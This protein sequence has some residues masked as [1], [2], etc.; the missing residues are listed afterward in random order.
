MYDVSSILIIISSVCIS[1]GCCGILCHE[2][3]TNNKTY[4]HTP[5]RTIITQPSNIIS[6]EKES[7]LSTDPP[8]YNQSL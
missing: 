7:L 4:R 2:C 8:P 3:K 1:L 5:K 6:S